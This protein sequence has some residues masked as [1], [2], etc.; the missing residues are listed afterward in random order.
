MTCLWMKTPLVA[1]LSLLLITGGALATA[2]DFPSREITVV[3]NYGAGGSTDLSTRALAAAM[4]QRLG[5]PLK[6]INRSGGAGTVGPTTLANSPND[7]YTIGVTS[8]SPMAIQPNLRAVPYTIDDFTYLGGYA[9]YRYGI[10]VHANSGITS[11]AALVARAK[12]GKVTFSASGPPNNLAMRALAAATGGTF[13][14][15]PYRSGK[16][17]TVAVL[18]QKV[19]ATVQNPT[20]IVSHVKNGTM[21]LLASASPVRWFELPEVPTLR[22]QGYDI[23]IDSW[24]GLAVPAGTDPAKVAILEAAIQQSLKDPDAQA[25]L[26]NLGMEPTFM[27]GVE[28]G[29]FLRDG[30]ARMGRELR[31]AGLVQ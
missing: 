30:R 3:V 27:T 17:A 21:L 6:V 4:E 20:D 5:T 9:R 10:A 28:Y 15:V 2:A 8:F 11:M 14:W 24:A 7:G 22:E 13:Q 1:L 16:A 25:V 26:M 19:D 23:A 29:A 18:G 12:D 31:E